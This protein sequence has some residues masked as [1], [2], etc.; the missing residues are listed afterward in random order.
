[1]KASF[2]KI[3]AANDDTSGY[4]SQSTE[5]LINDDIC[6]PAIGRS[7]L[8]KKVIA[9]QLSQHYTHLP[10]LDTY[11][12]RVKTSCLTIV[13]APAGYG[14]TS[15]VSYWVQNNS[16]SDSSVAWLSLDVRDNDIIRMCSYLI[17]SLTCILDEDDKETLYQLLDVRTFYLR[18]AVLAAQQIDQYNMIKETIN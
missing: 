6:S 15:L 2:S 8:R 12:Q 11:F 13:S 3:S 9:P 17:E 4:N 7:F 1:M 18:I 16:S 5:L 10:R 14:K